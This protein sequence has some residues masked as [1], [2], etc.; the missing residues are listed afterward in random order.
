[1]TRQS[2]GIYSALLGVLI[3][4]ALFGLIFW[5]AARFM[6]AFLAFTNSRWAHVLTILVGPIIGFN[7]WLLYRAKRRRGA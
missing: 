1:M 2:L 7:A 3:A 5:I 6:P 4:A